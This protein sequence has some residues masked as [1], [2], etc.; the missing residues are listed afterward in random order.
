MFSLTKT[1]TNYVTLT[2]DI[3]V[4]Y[5]CSAIY[6]R[7]S[8]GVLASKQHCFRNLF[9]PSNLKISKYTYNKLI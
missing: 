1:V 6:L 7:F 5:Y 3:N 4:W 9:Y 8:A 2:T